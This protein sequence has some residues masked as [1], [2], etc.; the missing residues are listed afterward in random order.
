M[1]TDRIR[2]RKIL[3][4]SHQAC[5]PEFGGDLL[6]RTG[7]V[8]GDLGAGADHLSGAEEKDDDLGV[9]EP[10]DESGELLGLVLDLLESE[11]DGDCVG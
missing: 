9:V 1:R 11:G 6:D 3:F 7:D 5:I 8:L 2:P 4:S 10:V